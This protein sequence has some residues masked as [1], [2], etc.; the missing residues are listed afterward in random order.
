MRYP[1]ENERSSRLQTTRREPSP[2]TRPLFKAALS[3]TLRFLL[4]P[5]DLQYPN[6]DGGPLCSPMI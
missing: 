1:M 5:N 6:F 2:P 4:S 3:S